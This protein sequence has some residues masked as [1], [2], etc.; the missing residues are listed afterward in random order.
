[1]GGYKKEETNFV[2]KMLNFYKK[3]KTIISPRFIFLKALK[4]NIKLF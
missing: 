3:F 1:M 4:N 2:T